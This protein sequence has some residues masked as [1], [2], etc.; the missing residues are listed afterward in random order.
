MRITKKTISGLEMSGYNDSN[1]EWVIQSCDKDGSG[2]TERYQ[3]SKFTLSEAFK[4]HA[5]LY[6][7]I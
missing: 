1:C 2:R 4:L 3:K 6:E 5:K 7:N